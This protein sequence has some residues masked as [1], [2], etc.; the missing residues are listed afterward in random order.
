MKKRSTKHRECW[1]SRVG[2]GSAVQE[3]R[4]QHTTNMAWKMV[5]NSMGWSKAM[6]GDKKQHST[7][8]ETWWTDSVESGR[9][10]KKDKKR[11]LDCEEAEDLGLARLFGG[12]IA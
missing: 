6:K 11:T 8:H 1:L 4:T 3:K 2:L 10:P 7:R 12:Q 9:K 5:P